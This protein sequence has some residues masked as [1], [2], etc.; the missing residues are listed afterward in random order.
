MASHRNYKKTRT[1]VNAVSW[2]P[3]AV[4][5]GN[6]WQYFSVKAAGGVAFKTRTDPNDAGTE[7]TIPAS[8]Q[9]SV[10][11]AANTPRFYE[12][13]SP[14]YVQLS[15]GTDTIVAAWVGGN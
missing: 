12:A 1:A 8:S 7:D 11:G 9:E 2:T 5:A 13:E 15:A 6:H 4:P 10:T 3:I 14:I